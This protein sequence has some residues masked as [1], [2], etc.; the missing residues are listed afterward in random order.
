[1]LPDTCPHE[2][3]V[4]GALWDIEETQMSPVGGGL[5][6]NSRSPSAAASP[7]GKPQASSFTSPKDEVSPPPPPLAFMP[8]LFP[9][10][11]LTQA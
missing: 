3:V 10:F 1:M 9:K 5:K 6:K 11:T 2:V 7:E 4:L 8:H